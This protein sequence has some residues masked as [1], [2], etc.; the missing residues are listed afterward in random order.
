M[1]PEVTHVIADI[2][3]NCF[4]RL[5]IFVLLILNRKDRAINSIIR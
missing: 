5:N 3:T 1:R 2:Q 4:S